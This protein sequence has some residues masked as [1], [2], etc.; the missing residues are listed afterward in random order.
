MSRPLVTVYVPCHNYGHYVDRAVESVVQQSLSDWELIVIDDGSSDGSADRCWEWG[1]RLG[2]RCQV[3]IH[4]RPRGL[5]ATA[6]RVLEEARGKYI[7]RLD[8]DD[9]LDE[10]ALLV[11]AQ[12]LEE[13]GEVALVYPNY[14]YVDEQGRSLG[15]ERRKKVGEEARLLDLPAHG[16]C[17]MVRRRVLKS[18]G[19]Y[20]ESPGAQD[21]YDL[22]L[23]VVGR[24]AVENVETPLFYYRQH[25]GS[26]SSDEE[27]ILSARRHIKRRMVERW[28]GPIK[29][30]ILGL[31]PAKNTYRDKPNIVLDEV[32]GRA[33]IDHSVEA[34]RQS[35]VFDEL[36]VTTDCKEVMA[37]CEAREVRAM[38]RP[39]VLSRADR[40]LSEVVHDAVTRLEIEADCHPD[41]VVVL[42]LHSPLRKAEDIVKA[43][44]SLRLYEADSVISV[45]ED[46]DLHFSH[47]AEGLEPINPA[48]M[49]RLRPEREGLYVYNG[50]ITASWRDVLQPGDM[51][52]RQITHVVMPKR[53]SI[54]LKSDFDRWVLDRVLRG[55]QKGRRPWRS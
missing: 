22:W 8:A 17:T 20:D 37:Y 41:I 25:D 28:D 6:N 40:Q 21:G 2:D 15:V 26:M 10:S 46:R 47:G 23:K 1:K 53:R 30:R 49:Q 32:G 11:M 48:M 50:A 12:R 52:G 3:W 14:V 31:I 24:Y 44:D 16:A 9:W 5:A 54:Q 55:D 43:V 36:W 13:K 35:E 39:A 19:G 34:A 18:L 4:R 27:R 29:P 42:S 33:L 38:L 45:Y 7:M 51:H